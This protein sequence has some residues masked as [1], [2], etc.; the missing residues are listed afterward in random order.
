LVATGS[1]DW[2]IRAA[3]PADKPAVLTLIN[4]IQPH[5]PW[6]S[7]HYDWQFFRG[8]A[9]PAEVR[10]IE[11]DDRV[12]SLYVGT[13]KNLW[14]DGTVRRGIMVQDVLTH[15]EYRGRGFLNGMGAAFLAEMRAWGDCGYTFPNKL[16]ENSFRRAGW[17]ELAGIPALQLPLGHRAEAK[18]TP[19]GNRLTEVAAFE[20]S[21]DAIW[22]SAEL[23]VGALRDAA[24]LN[25][26]YGRPQTTYRRF[27]IEGDRGYLVLKLYDRGEAKVM[28]V[29]DLVLR[30]DAR[31]LCGAVLSDVVALA[32]SAG[33][34]LLTAWLP[35]G[36]PY[37][38]QFEAT[39]LAPDQTNDRF[40]F[41]TGPD[42]VLGT[43]AQPSH[44]H[45]SQGDSDVY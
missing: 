12:V 32:A 15:P 36:H 6:S 25:W 34:T 44:W 28:H 43:L 40:A 9:G 39:G 22:H 7:E 13:R 5:I 23:R 41:T 14:I 26:R 18:A 16:S 2:S 30:A 4:L 45:L 3:G 24:Y 1:K 38:P 29:C 31:K 17:T 37:R 21:V 33:A 20:P 8:P 11:A 35:A 10:I 42:A 19:N 27:L